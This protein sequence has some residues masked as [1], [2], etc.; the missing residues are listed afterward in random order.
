MATPRYFRESLVPHPRPSADSLHLLSLYRCA[1]EVK[2]S[3]PGGNPGVG[4]GQGTQ[5]PMYPPAGFTG[6]GQYPPAPGAS[7]YPPAPGA[8]PYPPAPYP[9]SAPYPPAP[10]GSPYPPAPG[11]SPYPPAPGTSPYPPAP[12]ASPYPPAPGSSPYPPA[13]GGYPSPYP[14]APGAS[15]Y[16]PAP[17]ASPYPPAPGSSPYPPA[18]GGS[19]YPP[20]TGVVYPPSTG[21]GPYPAGGA[22]QYPPAAGGAY[23]PPGGSGYPGSGAGYPLPGG[24]P[25]PGGPPGQAPSTGY[26]GGSPSPNLTAQSAP[27][28]H[29]AAPGGSLLAYTEIPTVTAMGHFDPSSD[30]AALRKAMKGFGTDEAAIIA[31][32]SRRTS[33]QRQQIMLK[34]QQSYGREEGDDSKKALTGDLVK[35]LKSELSGKFEDVVIALMTPLPLFLATEIHNAIS[36]IGTNERTLVEILCTRDNASLMVIKNA[37]YQHYRKK[38]EEDLHGDTSGDF[39]RLLIS[40]CA[41]AR[42]ESNC[43]PALANSLAQQ[44]YKA[45]EGKMG[46]DEAEFNRIL[47]AYSYPLLRCVFDEYKK[48]KGK[49]FGDAIDSELSGDLKLG[50]K[51]VYQCIENRAA[52][53]AK[54]LRN[55][56]AGAG[57]NDRALIRLVVSR[58]EID[59]GNIKQ[60][61]QKLFKKPLEKD[62]KDDT[63]GDYKRVLLA[64]VEG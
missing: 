47:S 13:P 23:P 32:L 64:L 52:F 37:Y 38:L 17:G 2:M 14:P 34:Y 50:M 57:T 56:M 11:A 12:G 8:S 36:G 30:A 43:D 39:R 45:G 3:Y 54:E 18:P 62:I 49:T 21:A 55:S 48:I 20:T 53:F 63:S 4:F 6:S 42:D 44:L 16:P 10:G 40:M 33:D 27:R 22:Q 19:P 5:Y 7:P 51:T 25:Y 59:M 9:G 35:D 46:T 41:C 60:E 61:Y 15:P 24:N 1:C 28:T 31:I 26:P 58:S 29:A